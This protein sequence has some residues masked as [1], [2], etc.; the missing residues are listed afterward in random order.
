M[1]PIGGI[2]GLKN[3]LLDIGMRPSDFLFSNAILLV[4]G[5]SDEIFFNHLSNK[6][7]VPVGGAACQ[8]CTS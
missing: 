3:L 6:V 1:S 4:E 5:L 8:D 2:T 7:N